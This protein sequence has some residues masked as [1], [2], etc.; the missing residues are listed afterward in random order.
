VVSRG[1]C[2]TGLESTLRSFKA[3]CFSRTLIEAQ[4]DLVQ[5]GLTVAG[6]VGFLGQ[7]LA[8][9]PIGAFVAAALPRTLRITE[10]HLHIGGHGEALVLGHLRPAIPGQRAPQRRRKLAH[11]LAQGGDYRGRVFAGRLVFCG[12]R[13]MD[14]NYRDILQAAKA[15]RS[16]MK[17][18][19]T[20]ADGAA[21]ET[22]SYL[23]ALTNGAYAVIRSSCDASDI[24]RM[25]VRAFSHSEETSLA[26]LFDL[27]RPI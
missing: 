22:G 8:Q 4:R 11:M 13:L 21:L 14:G 2:N 1:R 19:V 25:A 10:V 20:F 18:V 5:L 24:E 15:G 27:A 7:V 9:K 23:Q 3:Q 17:I 6:Q 12:D 26:R 16:N